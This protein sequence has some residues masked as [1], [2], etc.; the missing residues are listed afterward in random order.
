MEADRVITVHSMSKTD[1]LA[2]ARMAVIE[3][4]DQQLSQRFEALNSQIQPN[5][6]RHLYLLFVL[7]QFNRRSPNLLA[8]AQH[9]FPRT[10]SGFIDRCRKPAR[11]AQSLRLDD[12]P[13]YGQ[14]VSF[15][16][17]RTFARRLIF[18]LAGFLFGTTRDRFAA[19]GNFCRAPKKDMKPAGQP[20]A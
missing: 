17:H 12:H 10:N 2:G 6:C 11:G 1:C 5:R 19:A 9:N 18:G 7:P 3:I 13:A 14:H 4:R 8:T 20:F 16:A 15:T